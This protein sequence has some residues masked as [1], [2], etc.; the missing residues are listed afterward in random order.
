MD[1]LK[2]FNDI[3]ETKNYMV[4]TFNTKREVLIVTYPRLE[5]VDRLNEN[6]FRN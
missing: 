4:R 5:I 6:A 1:F 3:T 2:I